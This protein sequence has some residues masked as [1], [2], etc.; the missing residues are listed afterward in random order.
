MLSSSATSPPPP[1]AP[2]V[3]YRASPR[4]SLVW[5]AAPPGPSHG[6]PSS[7]PRGSSRRHRLHL[8]RPLVDSVLA[9][10][11][12]N[13]TIPS[14]HR[15]RRPDGWPSSLAIRSSA[16]PRLLDPAPRSPNSS[17]ITSASWFSKIG[18]GRSRLLR[19]PEF[20]DHLHRARAE[21]ATAPLALIG[22]LGGLAKNGI[23]LGQGRRP[24]DLR[25]LAPAGTAGQ[26]AACSLRR[27]PLRRPAT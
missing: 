7:S 23:T 4:R 13:G 3:S 19:T 20:F 8:T 5:T 11:P 15:Q 24:D 9:A 26:H 14:G 21:A 25:P 18:A 6:L 16:Q 12:P 17:A 22:N 10:S 2:R 27:H 1:A